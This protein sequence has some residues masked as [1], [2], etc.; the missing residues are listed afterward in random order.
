MSCDQLG[1]VGTDGSFS[2]LRG[3]GGEVQELVMNEKI[4]KHLASLDKVDRRGTPQMLPAT[5]GVALSGQ[6]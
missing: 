5:P 4:R 3:S 2:D 1:S 6:R